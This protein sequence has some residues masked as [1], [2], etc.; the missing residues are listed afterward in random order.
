LA[1]VLAADALL[2]VKRHVLWLCHYFYAYQNIFI[3]E[4]VYKERQVSCLQ[5]E[6]GF[7]LTK[8]EALLLKGRAINGM[9]MA[10]LRVALHQ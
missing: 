4:I 10:S 8:T 5:K 1:R 3:F 2:L 9:L 7:N 6:K